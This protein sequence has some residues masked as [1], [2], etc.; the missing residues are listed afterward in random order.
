MKNKLLILAGGAFAVLGVAAAAQNAVPAARSGP[1]ADLTRQQVIDRV[2]QRFQQLDIDHDGRF[3]PE[4]A[5]QQRA[6]R[7]EQ[8]QDRMFARLDLDHDGSITRAEMAQAHAQMRERMQA[9]R[10]ERRTAAPGAAGE[11]GA[12]HHG[13]R[14]MHRRG[15]HGHGRMGGQGYGQRMFGEQGYVTLEQMRDRALQRFDRLDANHDGTV[16]GAERRQARAGMRERMRERRQ[17]R[18]GG[19]PAQAD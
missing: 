5:R 7:A 9:R 18:Q 14:A 3:T 8:R 1:G 16:T 15:W 2:Q 19:A 6:R 10:A 12:R 17:A 13:G 4:E 11:H